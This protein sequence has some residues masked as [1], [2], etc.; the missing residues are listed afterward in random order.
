MNHIKWT[1]ALAATAGALLNIAKNP[2]CFIIWAITNA[3]WCAIKI[4][5]RA[6]SEAL[7]WSANLAASVVGLF[8]W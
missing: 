7:L 1:L 5:Q 6:W 4:R 2:A 8:V 3:G